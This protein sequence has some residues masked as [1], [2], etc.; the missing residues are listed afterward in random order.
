MMIIMTFSELFLKI[1]WRDFNEQVFGGG[2]VHYID[3]I[4]SG[5]AGNEGGDHAAKMS[6]I[7]FRSAGM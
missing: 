5:E 6:I 1:F 2:T 3:S 7:G 4:A